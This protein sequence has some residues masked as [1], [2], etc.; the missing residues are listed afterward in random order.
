M[1]SEEATSGLRSRFLIEDVPDGEDDYTSGKNL[2]FQKKNSRLSGRK[3]SI[4]KQK[5][6]HKL[7]NENQSFKC[8]VFH[9]NSCQIYT[10]TD[11]NVLWN[12]FIWNINNKKKD[13]VFIDFNIFEKIIKKD[14]NERVKLNDDSSILEKSNL[15]Q[16]KTINEENEESVYFNTFKEDEKEIDNYPQEDNLNNSAN[17][18]SAGN[19]NRLISK[20]VNDKINKSVFNGS[21]IYASNSFVNMKD[22][23]MEEFKPYIINNKQIFSSFKI[24]GQ[25]NYGKN[26]YQALLKKSS[27][28]ISRKKYSE[29]KVKS[30]SLKPLFLNVKQ[31]FDKADEV[32]ACEEKKKSTS[33]NIC[34]LENKN[35]YMSNISLCHVP[36]M[37][38]SS[39]LKSLKCSEIKKTPLIKEKRNGKSLLKI[40]LAEQ[41]TIYKSRTKRFGGNNLRLSPVTECLEIIQTSS[42]TEC[43]HCR[44]HQSTK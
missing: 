20:E 38:E 21:K 18:N 9:K 31:Q 4:V 19:Y 13:H 5:F 3:N 2:S 22:K 7:L 29:D 28:D 40:T 10:W 23:F 43:V 35:L 42:N 1:T 41:L 24:K 44:T 17:F 8:E 6:N 34:L 32:K 30:P 36:I 27:K 12:K 14:N 25:L 15:K 37:S 26:N 11:F 33:P 16:K 39:N